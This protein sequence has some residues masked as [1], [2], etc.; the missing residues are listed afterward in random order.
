MTNIYDELDE[1]PLDVLADQLYEQ[2]REAS[3]AWR[4]KWPSHCQHC[5]GWGGFV[6]PATYH[7]PEDFDVCEALGPEFCHRCGYEGFNSDHDAIE[8]NCYSYGRATCWWCGHSDADGDP[9]VS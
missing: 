7:Q 8:E 6:F 3:E 9:A 4:A 5:G 1:M 2:M